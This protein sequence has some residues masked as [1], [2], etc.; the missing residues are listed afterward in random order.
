MALETVGALWKPRNPASKAF[1][2]GNVKINGQAFRLIVFG[3]DNPR[4]DKAPQ[5]TI[6]LATDD[7]PRAVPPAVADAALAKV[8]ATEAGVV[9]SST[10]V[11][12][13]S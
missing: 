8:A 11:I 13:S 2:T 6:A 5:Y 7:V 3:N 12:P 9:P 4:S 1:A 10:E